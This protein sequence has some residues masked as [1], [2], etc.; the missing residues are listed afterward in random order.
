MD[1]RR[2]CRRTLALMR[3]TYNTGFQ[4]MVSR[5][6]RSVVGHSIRNWGKNSRKSKSCL[7]PIIPTQFSSI[8]KFKLRVQAQASVLP[9]HESLIRCLTQ[10]LGLGSVV[11]FNISTSI[12]VTLKAVSHHRPLRS[13]TFSGGFD[14]YFQVHV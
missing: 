11:N 4:F 13:R 6:D 10:T 9:C 3:A 8:L 2:L 14:S 1:D 7:V 5:I 12:R